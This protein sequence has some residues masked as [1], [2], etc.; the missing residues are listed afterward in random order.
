MFWFFLG[1]VIWLWN[2]TLI[3]ADWRSG[4][5]GKMTL[6]NAFAT[7]MLTYALIDTVF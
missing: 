1:V 5:I 2:A 3:Y 7:G 6:F 4:N